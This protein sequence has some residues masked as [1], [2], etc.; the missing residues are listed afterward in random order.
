MRCPHCGFIR[1]TDFNECPY[2]GHVIGNQKFLN[3][4][5][6]LNN[7]SSIKL[8]TLLTV[9]F[10]NIFIA[11]LII[12]IFFSFKYFLTLS[13]YI[14]LMLLAVIF[15]ITNKKKSAIMI[16]ENLDFYF[17]TSLILLTTLLPAYFMNNTGFM[18]AWNMSPTL[19]HINPGTLFAFLVIPSFLLVVSILIVA[20]FF[21]SRKEKFRPLV[22]GSILNFH[23]LMSLVL[24]VLLIVAKNNP[25]V[26]SYVITYQLVPGD[27]LST[28][29][30][31]VVSLS[32]IV[33]ALIFVNFNVMLIGSI[34]TNSG[35]V[36]GKNKK[37]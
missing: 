9:V 21:V 29:E 33:N 18:N 35:T 31:V 7:H 10:I 22:T 24:F 5:V 23:F 16:V 6:T 25:S 36:Y 27:W 13:A 8:S 4:R 34:I 12:D 37:D 26:A 20:M 1:D 30:D 3:R 14:V 15:R 17:V 2:C 11:I 28:F 19:S 32:F